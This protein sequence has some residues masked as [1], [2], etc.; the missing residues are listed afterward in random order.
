MQHVNRYS[1]LILAIGLFLIS[2]KKNNTSGDNES[3]YKQQ[4]REMVISISAYAKSIKPGFT[5]IPQNGIELVSD[6]GASS[7]QPHKAYLD[8]IDGNGQEDLFFGYKK[9]DQATP[10]KDNNYLRALL[11][12]S[13]NAGKV[14]LVT[15]Y[16]ATPSKVNT[17]YRQNLDAGYISF[18]A[19]KRALNAIPAR[20]VHN[21]N[22]GIISNLSQVRNFLYLINPDAFNTKEAFINAVTAT[23]YDLLLMDLFI[24]DNI[25]FTAAEINQLKHKANGGKRM[26]ICYM[27]VGEAEQYRYY[28]QSSW[29]NHPPAWLDKENPSWAGNFKVKYWDSAWQH[30]IYGNDASYLKKIIDAGFD[31]AYLDIIDA[32]EYYEK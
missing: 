3:G 25:S 32:F 20:P 31:G 2:C 15:D 8:A 27:S 22:T 6:N 26:V 19:N 1:A 5:I 17:S 12:I 28:W 18:A 21:E 16:C 30:I 11:D 13:K 14:I 7:G 10:A 4:M 9:D 29:R 24:S 23:N